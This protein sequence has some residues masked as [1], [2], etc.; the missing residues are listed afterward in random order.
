MTDSARAATTTVGRLAPLVSGFVVL[1]VSL[2]SSA[3]AL[4]PLDAGDFVAASAALGVPHPTG[5]PLSTAT[6]AGAQLLPL[7]MIAGRAAWWSALAS[8]FAAIAWSMAGVRLARHD[9]GRL[10]ASVCVAMAFVTVD[11]L[12]LHARIPEAYAL[13]VAL[14]GVALVLAIDHARAPDARRVALIGL[15]VG[16][17]ITQHALW[18]PWG[19]VVGIHLLATTPRA[20]RWR[21]CVAGGAAALAGLLA[22]TW[23]PAAALSDAA[24]AWGQP[25]TLARWWDHANAASIRRGYDG[26]MWP[27]PYA[28]GVHLST[29]ASQL[30]R[31]LAGLAPVGLIAGAVLAVRDRRA[32]LVVLGLAAADGVY[33]A[34]INPMGLTDVQNGQALALALA[35]AAGVGIGDAVGGAFARR[36]APA[37]AAPIAAL[38]LVGACLASARPGA[39]AD[40]RHDHA[41]EDLVLAHLHTV[42]PEGV[43]TWATD[44]LSAAGLY[45]RVGLDARPDLWTIGRWALSDPA[46]ADARAADAPFDVVAA[47]V[48][49]EDIDQSLNLWMHA[50]LSAQLGAR[51]VHHEVA[52]RDTDLPGGVW[53]EH[54]WPI[55]T[56]RIGAP[57]SITACEPQPFALCGPG[58]DAAF[59]R[60]ARSV[61]G[62]DGIWYR[63]WLGTQWGRIGTTCVQRGDLTCAAE[64]FERAHAVAPDR[65][66]HVNGLALVLASTGRFES[67]LEQIE[68]A[69]TIDPLSRVALRNGALYAAVIG[70]VERFDRFAARAERL[71]IPL[72]DDARRPR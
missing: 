18:R 58:N 36:D 20:M 49:S 26:T 17:G 50:I 70:D 21:A 42:P 34:W 3:P 61:S 23:L 10:A 54:R 55:G 47:P 19:I 59:G 24:H 41:S 9:A 12:A 43:T 64:A 22:W 13:N 71:G 11:T 57:A 33:S 28:A 38:V 44:T 5:F 4:G 66:A 15:V 40:V 25:D 8:A 56:V 68:I 30:L 48:V 39:F 27:G 46:V 14:A 51:A 29:L 2:W 35:V 37:V 32:G 7:G 45:A 60:S 1:V 62:A 31:G 6:G 52:G 53:L 65:A 69:L 67:A 16:L 63:R 72:P